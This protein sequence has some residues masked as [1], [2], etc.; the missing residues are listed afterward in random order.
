MGPL[1]RRGPALLPAAGQLVCLSKAKGEYLEL[2]CSQDAAARDLGARAVAGGQGWQWVHPSALDGAGALPWR[3]RRCMHVYGTA[4]K[5][6]VLDQGRP[7]ADTSAGDQGDWAALAAR[8]PAGGELEADM[9][10]AHD[11]ASETPAF[12]RSGTHQAGRRG[13]D[14]GKW[15][16]IDRLLIS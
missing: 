14:M 9:A 5:A 4:F 15:E 13:S 10:L 7:E 2:F 16:E 12:T 3:L 8:F 11:L 1:S 6:G